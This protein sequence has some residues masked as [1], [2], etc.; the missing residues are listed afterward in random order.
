[1]KLKILNLLKKKFVWHAH[2]F[3]E[4]NVC[5]DIDDSHLDEI[6]DETKTPAVITS[7]ICDIKPVR[8]LLLARKPKY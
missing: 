1:M 7:H 2:R 8:F 3:F 6:F 4:S 5:Q